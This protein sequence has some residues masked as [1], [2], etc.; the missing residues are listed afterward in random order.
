MARSG[1]HLA[2]GADPKSP[3]CRLSGARRVGHAEGKAYRAIVVHSSAHDKRRQK[4]L[5]RELE[6]SLK[7]IKA[8]AKDGEK[9]V[10]SCQADAGAAAIEIMKQDTA[11]HPLKLRVMEQPRYAQGRPKKIAHA[12]R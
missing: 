5:E 12:Y 7:Q 10:F 1:A 8:L 6:A 2:L 11:Y 9:Q 3:G 4:R